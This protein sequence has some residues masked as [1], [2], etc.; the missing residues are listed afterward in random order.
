M[1]AGFSM[2]AMSCFPLASRLKHA[3]MMDFEF[4]GQGRPFRILSLD[5]M[6]TQRTPGCVT[7]YGIPRRDDSGNTRH[8]RNYSSRTYSV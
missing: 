1:T 4:R 5:K 7:S 6:R 2:V 8:G 3:G